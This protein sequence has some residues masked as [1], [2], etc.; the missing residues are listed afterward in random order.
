VNAGGSL[1]VTF[2][3]TV[4][5][6][7]LNGTIITNADYGVTWA[8]GVSAVG[9]PVT[10]TVQSA[11]VLSISKTDTPDPVQAGGLLTYTI[12]VHNSGNA[13]AT[14]ATIT[15]TTPANTTFAWADWGGRLV[16]HQVQWT[17]E[18]VNAGGSLTVTFVVTVSSPLPNGTLT[19]A[20]YGVTCVEGV[21]AVGSPVT[22][23]VSPGPGPERVYLP[24]VMR[25]R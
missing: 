7:L 6:P 12:V 19:N 20:D 2:V 18:T 24:L 13:D 9:S 23:T 11:P 15:D 8:E 5:S 4:S 25:N 1:T 14:G 22:T 3:V 16:G 17:G 10:T 21:G